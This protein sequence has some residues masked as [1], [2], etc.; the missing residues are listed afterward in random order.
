[1]K[2]E[3]KELL[4]KL[5]DLQAKYDN[6]TKD[7]LKIEQVKLHIK[8]GSAID[9]CLQKRDFEAALAVMKVAQM[10]MVDLILKAV[11]ARKFEQGGY[12]L[13][14]KGESNFEIGETIINRR[15]RLK[16]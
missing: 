3:I 12:L 14:S 10:D 15:N 4:Q 1:M 13:D 9:T 5:D 2:E 6:T 8:V 16:K 11:T 7:W